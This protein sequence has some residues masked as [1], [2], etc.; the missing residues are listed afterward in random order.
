MTLYLIRGNDNFLSKTVNLSCP[1]GY[2]GGY[3]Y[4]KRETP[5]EYTRGILCEVL[6]YKA[7]V[8][9]LFYLIQGLVLVGREGI[10]LGDIIELCVGGK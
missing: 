2:A 7:P 5:R 1:P 8:W 9:G 4:T 6:Y 10:F 3:L